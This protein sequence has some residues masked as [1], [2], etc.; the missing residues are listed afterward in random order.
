MALKLSKM[1]SIGYEYEYHRILSMTYI[2]TK[3]KLSMESY[4]DQDSR[5]TGSQPIKKWVESFDKASFNP[6][7]P[8]RPQAYSK[9]KAASASL[10]GAEDC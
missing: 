6:S 2:G 10:E 8:E 1:S 9:L 4:K 5:L 7:N 3:I